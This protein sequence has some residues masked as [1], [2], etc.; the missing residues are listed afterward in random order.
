MVRDILKCFFLCCCLIG[1]ICGC[2]RQEA[3]TA[4]PK[5]R[6][7]DYINK[8]FSVKRVED[9]KELEA[10]L[11]G[12]AKMRLSAWSD[13]QFMEAF[14]DKKREVPNL[15]I[16][17]SRDISSKEVAIT[18]QVSFIDRTA[19]KNTR[20]TTKKMADLIMENGIW[21][22]QKVQSIKMLVEYQDELALP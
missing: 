16:L 13:D 14:I 7:T 5:Q 9:R 15:K 21:L 2:T 11:T 20:V 17:E 18:Y 6:L 1:F 3:I 8:S 4:N 10:F 12:G 19:G 22:I